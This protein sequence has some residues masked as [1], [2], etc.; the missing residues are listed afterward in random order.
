MIPVITEGVELG[1]KIAVCILI[2]GGV[3]LFAFA[4]LGSI[5]ALIEYLIDKCTT[6]KR[7]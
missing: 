3:L 4:A 6:N 1:L 7:F 5:C 2:A